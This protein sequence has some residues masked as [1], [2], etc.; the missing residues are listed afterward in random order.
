MTGTSSSQ[1]AG[2]TAAIISVTVAVV[3]TVL[4]SP[5][6]GRGTVLIGIAISTY[7]SGYAVAA[8]S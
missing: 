4:I 8:A 3:V 1:A 6:W 2:V 5:P 7:L